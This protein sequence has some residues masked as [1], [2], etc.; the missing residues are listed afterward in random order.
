M[1]FDP[2]SQY[3]VGW[4]TVTQQTVYV[5]G[6][7][8]YDQFGN[9]QAVD[10]RKI[11]TPPQNT[12]IPAQPGVEDNAG[13][14]RQLRNNSVN[15]ATNVPPFAKYDST[16]LVDIGVGSLNPIN[17][18]NG[19]PANWS[20]T[21][22]GGSVIDS[23]NGFSTVGANNNTGVISS[24]T[25]WKASVSG[26]ALTIYCRVARPAICVDGAGQSS[27]TV[28][29]ES[30]GN[31]YG[32]NGGSYPPT[33][34]NLQNS[35]ASRVVSLVVNPQSCQ[36]QDWNGSSYARLYQG[37]FLNP[38][39]A[40]YQSPNSDP[41]Y[42]DVTV[43][44]NGASVSMWIDGIFLGTVTNGNGAL[45]TGILYQVAIG[46]NPTPNASFGGA[47]GPFFIQRFQI[48]SSTVPTAALPVMV[49]FVGDSYVAGGGTNGGAVVP[50]GNGVQQT[51]NA[52]QLMTSVAASG[53]NSTNTN[54]QYEW[55]YQLE[56]YCY[57]Q[58]GANFPAFG[59]AKSGY[60]L[61]YSGSFSNP[62][63]TY[64]GTTSYWDTLDIASCSIVVIW[65][66]V[67]NQ[68]SY[69]NTSVP[70][71]LVNVVSDYT[72]HMNYIAANSPQLRVIIFVEGSS[73]EN[74]PSNTGSLTPAQCRTITAAWRQQLRNA[75]LYQPFLANGT[76]PVVYIPIYENYDGAIDGNLLHWGTNPFNTVTSG[77]QQ[78]PKG[79]SPDVHPT[80]VGRIKIADLV[81]PTLRHYLLQYSYNQSGYA[82][83]AGNSANAFTANTIIPNCAQGL[84][85]V[86]TMGGNVTVGAP[87]NAPSPGVRLQITLIQDATASRTTTWNATYRNA[88]SWAAG[89][90]GQRATA[91]YQ[92][93]GVN[94]QYIG[95]SSAFA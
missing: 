47:L 81:W 50:S 90:A 1:A 92:Y 52:D 75:F 73:L 16:L 53:A 5:Q 87:V 38:V 61:A 7:T 4:N 66:T 88:P 17:T 78:G 55:I 20:Y 34:W 86:W 80:P 69:P 63:V 93:D 91:V 58:L 10:L 76:V 33:L 32:A 35:D 85:Q 95:G 68:S 27:T 30:V 14:T 60:T 54:G 2:K 25:N 21:A 94:W 89:T 13:F 84:V 56:S 67:N 82:Y 44:F 62:I 12:F 3:Q 6:S 65:D 79:A 18:W 48:S 15:G 64:P 9:I 28:W 29:F 41:N 57:K 49:G 36:I 37:T 19:L 70:N 74:M 59:A 39:D 42:W 8:I 83:F 22:G 72:Q 51:L 40:D 23:A 31:K 26:A 46:N 45:P 77:G 24:S 43:C 71:P 11:T